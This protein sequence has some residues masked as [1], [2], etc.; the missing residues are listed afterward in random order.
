MLI[1]L[2]GGNAFKGQPLADLILI[3][4]I[5]GEHFSLATL[6]EL[7]TEKAKIIVPPTVADNIPAAFTPQLDVLD[8][9][10]KKERYGI[11][12]EAIPMYNIWEE[13]LKLHVKGRGNGYIMEMKGER[14]YIS[15]NTQDIPEMWNLKDIDKAFISMNLPYTMS[16]ESAV[17]AVLE[18]QPKEMYPYH[19][20]GK[21]GFSDVQKFKALVD[22]ANQKMTVNLLDWYPK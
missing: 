11:T 9:G 10:E 16:I 13:T 4:D 22:Q 3:T 8:N 19:Y 17:D 7:N 2:G 12:V 20:R 6:E 5:H 18:F 21:D 15:G 14:I 1:L